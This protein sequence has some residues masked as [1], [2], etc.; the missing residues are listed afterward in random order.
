MGRLIWGRKRLGADWW[1]RIGNLQSNR[2]AISSDQSLVNLP[3]RLA[4]YVGMDGSQ[5]GKEK[6][7]D[8]GFSNAAE[9]LDLVS[10]TTVNTFVTYSSDLT[11]VGVALSTSVAMINHSCT[12]NVS[13]VYPNGPGAAKAMHVVA[14]KDLEP[15]DELTTFYLDVSDPFPIRQKTLEQRYSFQCN[16]S[17]CKKSEI[18]SH[19]KRVR[20]DA[21]E[22]LW[23][24]RNGCSG[25]VAAPLNGV[26]RQTNVCTK[27]KLECNLDAE[28]VTEAIREGKETLEKVDL[29]MSQGES[30]TEEGAYF[31][32]HIT[33][34][35]TPHIRRHGRSIANFTINHEDTY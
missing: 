12:P 5:D 11:A 1:R 28:E 3:M 30:S 9:L 21:R 16:C 2:E 25:W 34:T 13:V 27:C 24:G 35:L 23:C 31:A 18:A 6:M 19:R 32:E 8:F 20:V 4:V 26:E 14:M 10:R 15:G 33:L 29:M 22:A 7:H 17:L